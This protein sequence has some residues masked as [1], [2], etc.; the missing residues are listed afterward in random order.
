[1]TRPARRI[2]HLQVPYLVVPSPWRVGEAVFWPAGELERRLR[3]QLE[4]REIAEH[5]L[6]PLTSQPWATVR[7]TIAPALD[8]RGA[9]NVNATVAR[10]RDVMRDSVAL[11][12]LFK[13]ARM[14]AGRRQTFG[15]ATDVTSSREDYWILRRD[16][17]WHLS[18]GG[19]HG[20]GIP[21]RFSRSDL[22]A[23][24]RDPRM[25]YLERALFTPEPGRSEW[26]PRAIAALRTF[27][28][29]QAYRPGPRIV[30]A[31]T[32]IE[33]LFGDGFLPGVVKPPASAHVLASRAAFLW[34]GVEAGDP[35]GGN[36]HGPNR[37]AC[38]F[39]T[40]K[41]AR[42]LD[43]RLEAD[44]AV[45]QRWRCDYYADL[46]D[47]WVDRNAALHGAELDAS[48][49]LASRREYMVERIF[50]LVLDWLA[51][52]GATRFSE[53]EGAIAALPRA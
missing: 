37:P 47:L 30:L 28:M 8:A 29:G 41:S 13:L 9:V 51:R 32:T 10:A 31:A 17:R 25:A 49:E 46:R 38:P 48:E 5:V 3:P 40:E 50:L 36:P 21:W 52:T 42:S 7:V 45:G 22:A 18:G 53:L 34:C 15:L 16:G 14:R 6:R 2:V 19:H 39:L 4:G 23:F 26:Q 20:S 11:L 43:R 35:T 44:D 27:S 33:A 24:R 1:M 12:T